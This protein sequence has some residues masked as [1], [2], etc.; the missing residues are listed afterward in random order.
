MRQLL[1]DR[2]PKKPM[3][4]GVDQVQVLDRFQ[5]ERQRE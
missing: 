2:S 4:L 5:R 3:V 1:V